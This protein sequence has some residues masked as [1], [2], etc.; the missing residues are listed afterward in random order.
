MTLILKLNLD[1]FGVLV[2][3]YHHTKNE[4]SM[5]RHSKVIARADRQ[6]DR[7]TDTQY[8]NIT[9]PH[10]RVVIMIIKIPTYTTFKL[11]ESNFAERKNNPV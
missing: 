7:Q 10:T 1:L 3:M 11:H 6:T 8:E 5:L 9:F 4:V 2:K